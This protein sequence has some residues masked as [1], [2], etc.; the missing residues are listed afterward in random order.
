MKLAKAAYY[1]FHK[2]IFA[3]VLLILLNSTTQLLNAQTAKEY[4]LKSAFLLHVANFVEWPKNSKVNNK[5]E[6]FVIGVFGD[7]P[8]D[9]ILKEAIKTKKKVIKGKKIS[10]KLVNRI[11]DVKETDILFISSSE[12][13]NLSKILKQTEKYPVLTIGDTKGYAERGIMINIF[14]SNNYL[15]FD[16]NSK[17][18]KKSNFY[19]SSKLLSHAKKVIN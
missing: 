7:D 13:Y 18:Y 3:V 9:N 14:I 17:A 4:E 11:D 12:K 8:F 10:I 1:L 6:E 15:K 5:N 16:I 19:I 2:I